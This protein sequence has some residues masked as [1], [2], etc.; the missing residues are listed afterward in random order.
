MLRR[1]FFIP[2]LPLSLLLLNGCFTI[3]GSPEEAVA[4]PQVNRNQ[5]FVVDAFRGIAN[6][7]P[8]S[9]RDA[10]RI[11]DE[12][13]GLSDYAQDLKYLSSWLY[14]ALYSS[15]P[16]T[17]PMVE[18]LPNSYFASLARDIKNGVYPVTRIEESS[19]LFF[20]LPPMSVLFADSTDTLDIAYESL[21]VGHELNPEGTLPQ[22]LLGYV[23]EHRGNHDDAVTWYI[24]ALQSSRECYPAAYGMVRIYIEAGRYEE[25]EL[26]LNEAAELVVP[27]GEFLVL[28]G[29]VELAQ[30]RFS[31]A[32]ENF[33]KARS[34]L[35]DT[36]GLLM[37][38]GRAL[39]AQ[40]QAEE[41]LEMVRNA[42]RRGAGIVDTALLEANILRS[43]KQRIKALSVIEQAQGQFSNDQRLKD[44]KAQLLLETGRSEEGRLLLGDVSSQGYS[45]SL[46]RDV[47]L[48]KSAV[49]AEL[50]QEAL[51]YFE[52]ASEQSRDSEILALGARIH[53]NRGEGQEA[54]ELYRE[55]H[56]SDPKNPE[57][58]LRAMEI[59][60]ANED[61]Q[62][63]SEMIELLA[64]ME[65]DSVQKSRRKVGEAF[66]AAGSPAERKLLEEAVFLHV[67]NEAALLGLADYHIRRGDKR[68]AEL[69]LRQLERTP[70][71]EKKT[72]DRILV[73]KEQL[74]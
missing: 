42:R 11:L 14:S 32:Q 18:P 22:Y 43:M 13:G 27:D 3:P 15:L 29:R 40:K 26:V 21:T 58:P 25:A 57:Y 72:R 7:S 67:R 4:P 10:Y 70:G 73:L 19:Y 45:E 28:R 24:S 23:E 65:L 20:L 41:A 39:F 9:L 69:Y 54:L 30:G 5:G 33:L 36:P 37:G 61:A 59:A 55:L 16:E 60:T 6:G 53:I 2:A 62:V 34:L 51:L 44:L 48:M 35:G 64:G 63:V 74:N 49:N 46:T 66:L 31:S 38:I 71:L 8:G 12:E 1:F 68:R 52:H 47:L 56:T 50:W 17:L